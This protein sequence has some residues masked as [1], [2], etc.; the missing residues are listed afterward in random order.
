MI[1]EKNQIKELC[2]SQGIIPPEELWYDLPP[3]VSDAL[4]VGDINSDRYK[5]ISSWSSKPLEFLKGPPIIFNP[6][7]VGQLSLF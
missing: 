4:F 6:K 3:K 2:E 1:Y 7:P 5:R